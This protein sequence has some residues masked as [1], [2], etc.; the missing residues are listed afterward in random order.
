[1]NTIHLSAH[2]SAF[3]V[4]SSGAVGNGIMG[5]HCA[6][7]RGSDAKMG[8]SFV[9]EKRARNV[10]ST[11]HQHISSGINEWTAVVLDCTTVEDLKILITIFHIFLK[12]NQCNILH[13]FIFHYYLHI[14]W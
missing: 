13:C 7:K 4:P 3:T 14:Y 11:H 5:S 2:S 6:Q 9:N 12:A 10:C 8:K 1:M